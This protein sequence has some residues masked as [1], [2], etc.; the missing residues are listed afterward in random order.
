MGKRR[1]SES[2]SSDSSDIDN[3]YDKG[4]YKKSNKNYLYEDALNS[5]PSQLKIIKILTIN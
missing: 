5:I 3:N 1:H 2:S 4:K